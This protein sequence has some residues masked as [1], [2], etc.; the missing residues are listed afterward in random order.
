MSEGTGPLSEKGQKKGRKTSTHPSVPRQALPQRPRPEHEEERHS[1]PVRPLFGDQ[2]RRS[3]A[4]ESR[5]RRHRRERRHRAGK[6]Q[7]LRLLHRHDGGDEE[8]LVADLGDEDHAPGLEEPLFCVLGSGGRGGGGGGF[9][10]EVEV[11][12][13]IAT[14]LSFSSFPWHSCGLLFV[15]LLVFPP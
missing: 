11:E 7:L 6:H 8:G 13:A 12:Q 2:G 9:G 1:C 3:P 14:S 5:Q 4:Q 15:I 10:R